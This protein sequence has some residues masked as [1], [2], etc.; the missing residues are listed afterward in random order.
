MQQAGVILSDFATLMVEILKDN[1]AAKSRRS[2][3]SARYGLGEG[4]FPDAP[5][6]GE[7]ACGVITRKI[8]PYNISCHA[9]ARQVTS[10]PSS[11]NRQWEFHISFC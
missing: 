10:L 7:V 2:L 6:E 11:E 4:A 1:A 3:W 5:A 9:S 8:I